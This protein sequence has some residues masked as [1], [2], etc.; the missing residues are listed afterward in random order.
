[1]AV[2]NGESLLPKFGLQ[3]VDRLNGELFLER[4]RDNDDD[5]DNSGE[6][7]DDVELK[8]RDGVDFFSLFF[9]VSFAALTSNLKRS[10]NNYLRMDSIK[11]WEIEYIYREKK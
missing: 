9:F 4:E 2:L 11:Q 6:R 8:R 3:E 10:F 7:V 5:K 1:M